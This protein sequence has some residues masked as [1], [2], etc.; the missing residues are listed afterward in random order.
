MFIYLFLSNHP[1]HTPLHSLP[2]STIVVMTLACWIILMYWKTTEMIESTC[3]SPLSVNLTQR[4]H[5][6]EYVHTWDTKMSV[7]IKL[8]KATYKD[9]QFDEDLSTTVLPNYWLQEFLM[10]Q[11]PMSFSLFLMHK[12]RSWIT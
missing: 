11:T 1:S 12:M 3:R 5:M 8:E 6:H 2:F 9:G 7:K 4:R 10:I